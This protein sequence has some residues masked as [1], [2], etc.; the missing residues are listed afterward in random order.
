MARKARVEF[1]G[2]VYHVLGRGDRREAIFRDDAERERFLATLGEA[3]LRTGWRV[4]ALVLMS[5]S[6][7]SADPNPAGQSRGRDA[8]RFAPPDFAPA[9]TIG[10]YVAERG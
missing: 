10:S 6:L 1:E 2:A 7:P 3:C 8:L 9:N 5:K 4:H